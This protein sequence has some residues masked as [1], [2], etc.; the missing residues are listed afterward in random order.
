[1]SKTLATLLDECRKLLGDTNAAAYVFS[2]A[3]LTLWINQALQELS[4]YFPL[5]SQYT[6]GTTAGQRTYDLE[7]DVLQVIACEYPAGQIPPRFLRR[8]PSTALEFWQQP[9]RFDFFP[10]YDASEA[11]PPQLLI[12]AAPGE[13][14]EIRLEIVTPHRPLTTSSDECSLPETLS[15]LIGLFVRWRALA[16]LSTGEMMEASPYQPLAETLEGN[17]ARAEGDYR[18][19]LQEARRS[20]SEALITQWRWEGGEQVY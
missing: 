6:L 8:C 13:G 15:P 17:A 2:D 10:R 14:E 1:M 3:Q 5:R 9:D 19:A 12:S 16:E 7:V 18:R 4:L 20:L 11:N